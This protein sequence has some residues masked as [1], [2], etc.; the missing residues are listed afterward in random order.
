MWFN[1]EGKKERKT[2]RN[3]M[4]RVSK[5]IWQLIIL[6]DCIPKCLEL[7]C[8]V[9]NLTFS[10]SP[11]RSQSRGKL[12]LKKNG[13]YM[14]TGQSKALFSILQRHLQWNTWEKLNTFSWA[15]VGQLLATGA[16]RFPPVVYIQFEKMHLYYIYATRHLNRKGHWCF[17]ITLS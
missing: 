9:V 2:V 8:A 1:K 13:K 3:E 15:V 12:I 14:V 7:S 5:E 4:S 11:S 10:A 17:T 16:W 6:K